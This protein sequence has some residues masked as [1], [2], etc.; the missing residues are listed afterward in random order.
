MN[1]GTRYADVTWLEEYEALQTVK[2]TFE[3]GTLVSQEVVE[4]QAIE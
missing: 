4:E 2:Y 3:N 1:F